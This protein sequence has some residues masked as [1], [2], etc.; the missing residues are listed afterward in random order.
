[1]LQHTIR[2]AAHKLKKEKK[3][4]LKEYKTKEELQKELYA[5]RSIGS[6]YAPELGPVLCDQVNEPPYVLVMERYY[7]TLY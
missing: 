4:V 7:R 6:K 1:M 3:V 2:Y 5:I